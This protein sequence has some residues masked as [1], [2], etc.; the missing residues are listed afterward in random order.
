MLSPE[1]G[2]APLRFMCVVSAL[3]EN[4]GGVPVRRRLAEPAN[5][6]PKGGVVL[7]PKHLSLVTAALLATVLVVLPVDASVA[8]VLATQIP[9]VERERPDRGKIPGSSML[10][11]EQVSLMGMPADEADMEP[12]AMPVGDF[13]SDLALDSASTLELTQPVAPASPSQ[14]AL[15]S[16]TESLP[17]AERDEF[18]TTFQR[19]DGS[20]ILQEATE[21]INYQNEGQW[22]EISTVIEPRPGGWE[23][24]SHP[25]APEFSQR[26]N[27]PNAVSVSTDGHALSF[28][29]VGIAGGT[30]VL[31]SSAGDR[32]N[33]TLMYH[34]VA[35]HADLKYIVEN[36]G[37]KEALVLERAPS[38][39]TWSWLVEAP[40]L[41]PT[42]QDGGLVEFADVNGDVVMHI[43]APVVWDSSG[44]EGQRSDFL[45]NPALRLEPVDE[46][47][48]KYTVEVDPAWLKAAER[49]YPVYI[50]P[51][52]QHGS[53]YTRSF[54]S[55]GA[56]YNGELHVGNTRQNNQNVYWRALANFNYADA[57]GK[58]INY[59]QLGIGYGGFA[60]QNEGG[61]ISH[62]NCLGYNCTG[63]GLTGYE[64][65]N[66][67]TWTSGDAIRDRLAWAFSQG[68]SGVTFMIRG[69]EHSHYSHKRIGVEVFI[70][71]WPFPTV[72][73]N[74]PSNGSTGASLTPTLTLNGQ[75]FSPYST[76][77]YWFKVSQNS[78]MSNVLW[79]SGWIN[80]KQATVPEGRLR[81]DTTYYW[82]VR[83]VDGH[84]GQ[85]GQSTDRWS[86]VWNLK[87]Q[88][89]PETPPVGS[90]SPGNATGLPEIVTSRTPTLV[91][92]SVSDPDAVPAG[93]Q[94]KYEFKL[95]TGSD[96]RTGAV[97]TSGL[98]PADPDG[99]VRWTVPE[100]TLTDGGIY[101]WIVQPHDG[102]S[103][104]VYPAWVK[105]FKVD[106]RLGS[107]G[108]SPFDVAGPV[109]VNMANGNANVAF[110]SPTVQTVGGPMGMSFVYNSQ[111]VRSSNYG[112]TGS[113]F[114]ARDAAG[115]IPSSPTG[116][117][118][119]GKA[120][121]MVRNDPSVSFE[122]GD[123][124][125][126][127]AVP[128]DHFITRWAGFVRLPHASSRWRFGV[129]HDDG[130][131][132][133]VNNVNV[134][135]R[136]QHGATP[137]EWGGDMNLSTGQLPL[138]LDFF[139]GVGA[140]GVELWADDMNDSVGPVVVPANWLSRRASV[141]PEGWSASVPIA[142]DVTAWA[143]AAISESAVVLTD[144]TGTAHTHTKASAGGYTPPEGEYGTV[145]LDARGR[146]VYR[147]EDGTI[148]QFAADG[149]LESATPAA[150]GMRPAT[151]ILQRDSTGRVSAVLDPASKDGNNYLRKV[152]F[153]YFNGA[154]DWDSQNCHGLPPSYWTPPVGMLCK[155]KYPD[156]L[157]TNLYYGPNEALWMI[158]DPGAERTWF[159]YQDRI[160]TGIQD[161]VASDYLLS[162]AEPAQFE[163]PY[164]D[165]KYEGG[166]VTSVTQ[167]AGN[168]VGIRMQKAYSY[169]PAA[170]SASVTL[171]DVPDSTASVTYDKTWRQLTSSSPMGS[172]ATNQWH[173]TK[174]L[175]LA[176][177]TTPG[178]K[179]T[180]IYDALTDRKIHEYGPAP[181][182]CFQ[183]S[184]LPISNPESATDCGIVPGHTST[185]YDSG[186]QGLNA[187]Y[188]SNTQQLT[189]QPAF[190]SLGLHG[191]SGGA[192]VRDWGTD[193][194]APG[195]S[196]DNFSVRL[197]GLITFPTAGTYRLQTRSDDGVRLWLN[198]II[199]ID[200]WGPQGATDVTSAEIT[201]VAGETRRV[202]LEY[203]EVTGPAL[204]QLKWATPSQG[205][206]ET[207]PGSALQPDYGLV[208]SSTVDDSIPA[209]SGLASTAVPGVSTS[210][211]YAHPWLGQAVSATL[212]PGGLNLK[213]ATTYE[214]PGAAGWLR[215][216]SKTLPAATG[217]N[218]PVS[219]R[220]SYQHWGDLE[221]APDVCNVGGVRQFGALKSTTG[222]SATGNGVI[223]EYVYDIMGRVAGNKTSGD[224]DWSCNEYDHRGDLTKQTY[225][226]PAG[227][228]SRT[229]VSAQGPTNEVG[230][231]ETVADNSVAGSP[232]GST[233]T[234][235]T[236]LIGQVTRY[237]DV[238]GTVTTTEYDPRTGRLMSTS[239]TPAGGSTSKTEYSYDADGKIT[240]VK[241]GGTVLAAPSYDATQQLKSIIYAGGA[242]LA[243]VGRDKAARLTRLNWTFP[244]SETIT[245]E[246][247]RS[248]SGRVA[249]NA[250]TRGSTVHTSTYGYD[251]AG[252]LTSATIPS[253][254]LSYEYSSSG[255]CGANQAAGASGNR[256]R[257]TD[258][259]TAPGTSQA[260]VTTTNYCYDWADR[261]TSSAVTGAVAGAHAVADGLPS[262]EI[263]Y[264]AAG[265]MTRLG[266]MTVAY[267]ARGQH[268][269]ITYADGTIVKIDR[270]PE[271]RVVAQRTTPAGGSESVTKYLHSGDVDAPWASQ[272]QS[273]TKQVLNLPGGAS[274]SMIGTN[275]EWAY[276]GVLGHTIAAGNGTSTGALSLHDPFGQP[277][278]AT[279]RAIGTASADDSNANG[280][281]SGWHQESMKLAYRVGTVTML[282]MGSR[283]YVPSLGRFLQTDPV[284]G[285]VDNDYAWPTDPIGS[286]DLDG[287]FDWLLALDIASTAMMFI[288]GVGTA[289]GLAIKGAVIATRLVVGIAK[290]SKIA[291]VARA[292][293][294]KV[295]T[296]AKA[297]ATASKSAASK[298][299]TK[300]K[301]V[302]KNNNI[303]RVG[304][305]TKG[306][307]FRVSIGAQKKHWAKLPGWR[308]RAQPIHI[309]MERRVG[310]ITNNRTGWEK[311][312]WRRR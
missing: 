24:Q 25:L 170:G 256:S 56:V 169:D 193:A 216:E 14:D 134:L 262:S 91:V 110:N 179:T 115:N 88:R 129:K 64:I 243:S 133:R 77:Q 207:V 260:Q 127:G 204:L 189:G 187:A 52:I 8:S 157:E 13:S 168:G 210:F 310:V 194:P 35:P 43:P 101:S 107:T 224:A 154:T 241:V 158:E 141:L 32:S 217:T 85:G 282:E 71:Y 72:G 21:P 163:P 156:G 39:P 65:S 312:M 197:T 191:A 307:P 44:V 49:E 116:Y 233:I 55:D 162:R 68:D 171:P 175:L 1:G 188:Y 126:G 95:A 199:Q 185:Q 206:F 211:E 196:S 57:P 304:P 104:N 78:D 269:M 205:S 92:D 214:Q 165:V 53:A 124:S 275:R 302:V 69:A 257:V 15:E 136:W 259:Y 130:V 36:T 22:E 247:V 128:A 292:A 48:W 209:N 159:K 287:E 123:Q 238:W 231:R 160:L 109:A 103:K 190:F 309:H 83:T 225:R 166:R 87:T 176:S 73:Q 164:L 284:E 97:H 12:P 274:V 248:Q 2:T 215:R 278:H 148:Y 289:A 265:N 297:A 230:Q 120:P 291:T 237:E 41:K 119:D 100:G 226:G 249:R 239:T 111:A 33:D 117:S 3:S 244:S 146:V 306:S 201:V 31:E 186:M 81:P 295:A 105:K 254:D 251:A 140:A 82:Q 218:A 200:K 89:V 17:V 84:N 11:A 219:A 75:G 152:E 18:S 63:H 227:T 38:T 137:V 220:T 235:D 286:S 263:T 252:R 229:V 67:H 280:D 296:A 70:E 245:D 74:S 161:T 270:D 5:V 213:T 253:H 277:L 27:A 142:G 145:S 290:A 144:A 177:T 261:L 54:K 222:P 10:T 58:F 279:N 293:G 173:P 37:V 195:V 281:R 240:S 143:T 288:P 112:L 47:S 20:R 308:Q 93:G 60:S 34:N 268:R 28:S 121:L 285:G 203:H 98:I 174:D 90:A 223:T 4:P 29:M 118:L 125:P 151:P 79:E 19:G 311:Y 94:V 51:T 266:D 250:V 147:D 273:V 139:E 99:K 135:D 300:F 184:G 236:N 276:A 283:L 132:L 131:R 258:R 59:A 167:P 42:V 264:D 66:N 80:E 298:A 150:D 303:L 272:S 50:D 181:E 182:A 113:Y 183:A 153:V 122:W 9:E 180:N 212:N 96:G 108:P 221:S 267:D 23:V 271:G 76:P 40:S 305:T 7:R 62:A 301:H 26:A 138:Q 202:R 178:V 172:T 234:I 299:I 106:M 102:L 46:T 255:G 246:V 114:D 149:S 228:P 45:I 232:N 208:T 155:I 16:E 6:Y 198:D 294:S 192:V 86:G 242:Q 61:W 30:P